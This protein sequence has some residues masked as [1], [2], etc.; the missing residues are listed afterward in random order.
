[1]KRQWAHLLDAQP[2]DVF[3]PTLAARPAVRLGELVDLVE[4][5][6]ADACELGVEAG[7]LQQS[8]DADLDIVADVCGQVADSAEPLSAAAQER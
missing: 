2:A 5:N 8:G 3:G 1:V 7:G 4:V 6:D